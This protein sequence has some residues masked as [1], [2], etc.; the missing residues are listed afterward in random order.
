MHSLLNMTYMYN[1]ALVL[2]FFPKDYLKT[3][4]QLQ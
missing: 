4:N 3:G 1:Q 2:T